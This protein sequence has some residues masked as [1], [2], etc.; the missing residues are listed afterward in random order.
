M[1]DCASGFTDTSKEIMQGFYGNTS[2]GGV[3]VTDSANFLKTNKW[4]NIIY[5]YDGFQSKIYVDGK[6]RGTI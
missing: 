5:T 2:R 4:I 1:F 6:L 3:G